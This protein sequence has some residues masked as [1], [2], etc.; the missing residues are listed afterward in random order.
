MEFIEI[1]KLVSTSMS[2]IIT[3]CNQ[4][5]KYIKNKLEPFDNS[6]AIS[7]EKVNRKKQIMKINEGLSYLYNNYANIPQNYNNMMQRGNYN[8]NKK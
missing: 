1:N 5:D 7:Y 4:L 3:Y 2:K 8:G 6:I